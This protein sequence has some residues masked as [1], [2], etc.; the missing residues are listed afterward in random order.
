MPK[1]VLVPV[2]DGVRRE[3]REKPHAG[4]GAEKPQAIQVYVEG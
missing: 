4:K 3:M 2:A 1:K